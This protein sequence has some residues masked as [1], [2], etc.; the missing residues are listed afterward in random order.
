MRAG[1]KDATRNPGA[2]H[3]G[4]YSAGYS[5]GPYLA[6]AALRVRGQP[7]AGPRGDLAAVAEAELGQDVLDV[8]LRRPLRDEQGLAD[9]LVRQPA[10][11][12]PGHLELAGA[13]R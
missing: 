1:R 13:Q 7:L 11:D 6:G 3:P 9:L 4:K 5:F 8:V 12:Q 2:S 10:R